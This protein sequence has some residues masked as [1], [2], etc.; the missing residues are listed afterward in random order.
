GGA[1][2]RSEVFGHL[3]AFRYGARGVSSSRRSILAAVVLIL[4]CSSCNEPRPARP[5]VKSVSPRLVS[6][7]TSYPLMLYGTA[8]GPGMTV[9]IDGAGTTQTATADV[10]DDERATVRV[11][12]D[13]VVHPRTPMTRVRIAVAG[14]DDRGALLEVVNDSRFPVLE[15]LEGDP[16]GRRVFVASASTDA[17]WGV[18]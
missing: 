5:A 14:G 16:D 6:D 15:D 10:I 4:P 8:F 9:R 2:G 3:P 12:L 7:Q 11:R 13:G 17:L 1:R 18:S